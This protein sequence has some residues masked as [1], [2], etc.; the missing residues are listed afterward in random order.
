MKLYLVSL[1]LA[2]L[3]AFALA[4]E[5]TQKAVVVTYPKDTPSS[6]IEQAMQ[7]IKDAGGSIT[8]EYNLIKGFAATTST[9]ALESV[10]A[11]GEAYNPFIE[12]DVMVSISGQTSTDD[13]A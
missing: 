12:E 7:A 13:S 2:L 9:K 5:E 11:M 4:G 8:H 3:A 6:V 1:F 10:R